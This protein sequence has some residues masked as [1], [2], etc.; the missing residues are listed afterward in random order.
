MGALT[1][2]KVCPLNYCIYHPWQRGSYIRKKLAFRSDL[3]RFQQADGDLT[4]ERESRRGGVDVAELVTGYRATD[5]PDRRRPRM[6][7]QKDQRG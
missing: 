7:C 4:F 6:L 2:E 1:W 5:L 3:S